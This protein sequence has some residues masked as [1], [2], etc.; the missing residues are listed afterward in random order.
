MTGFKKITQT[1][2]KQD[3]KTVVIKMKGDNQ[4]KATSPGFNLESKP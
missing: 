1:Y 2:V 3:G 4:Y